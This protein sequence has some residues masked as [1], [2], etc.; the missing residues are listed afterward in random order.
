MDDDEGQK[1]VNSRF[2][3]NE[4]TDP[5]TTKA[6]RI[7]TETVVD[8][9]L[10]ELILQHT[11]LPVFLLLQDV[12]HESCL[13][14]SQEAS[15]HGDGRRVSGLVSHDVMVVVVVL[16]VVVVNRFCV[17]NKEALSGRDEAWRTPPLAPAVL[18]RASKAAKASEKKERES[19][20]SFENRP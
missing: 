18:E 1:P 14:C 12:V 7:L 3:D 8:G 13:S 10:S 9:D 5:R 15:Y 6:L 20:A 17:Q 11:N 19:S 16:S 4:T 2:I